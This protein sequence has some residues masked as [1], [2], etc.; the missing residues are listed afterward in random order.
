[1]VPGFPDPRIGWLALA[2]SST[3]AGN[4]SITA[5]V[6]NIIVVERASPEVH[7][8]FRQYFRLGLP[9]TLLTLMWG[10]IW[11]SLIR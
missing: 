8:G 7:I 1:L 5:S 2:M 11:L 10:I 6:A 3:L 9:L 4:L